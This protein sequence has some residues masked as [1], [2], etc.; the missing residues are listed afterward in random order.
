MASVSPRWVATAGPK[1][2]LRSVFL[3]TMKFCQPLVAFQAASMSLPV[4]AAYAE[5]RNGS[6]S[7]G[8]VLDDNSAGSTSFVWS[9]PKVCKFLTSFIRYVLEL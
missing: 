3:S 6:S 8:A 1:R 5:G 2:D 4:T 7:G 9:N